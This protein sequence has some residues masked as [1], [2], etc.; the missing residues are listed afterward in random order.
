[1]MDDNTAL[2]ADAKQIQQVYAYIY[3]IEDQRVDNKIN[4]IEKIFDQDPLQFDDLQIDY[5]LDKLRKRKQQA[6]LFKSHVDIYEEEI[7]HQKKVRKQMQQ[8]IEKFN[9]DVTP[10]G[11][12]KFSN[13]DQLRL[14]CL[15]D[16]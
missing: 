2:T 6:H 10:Q 1:M 13:E 7:K 12:Q 5:Q 8:I 11:L 14:K 4:T 3:E 15:Q 9:I 16:D